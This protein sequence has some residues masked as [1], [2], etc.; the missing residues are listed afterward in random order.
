M[1]V[2][3]ERL[4]RDTADVQAGTAELSALNLTQ[5]MKAKDTSVDGLTK[6][7]EFLLKKNGVDYVKGAGS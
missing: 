3:E 6:G 4:G 2:V 5:M 1:G 7:V